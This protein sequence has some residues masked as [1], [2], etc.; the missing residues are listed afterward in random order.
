MCALLFHNALVFWTDIY[1]LNSISGIDFVAQHV[2]WND[3]RPSVATLNFR[4]ASKS[5]TLNHAVAKLAAFGITTVVSAGNEGVDASEYSPAS[6]PTAITVGATT[7]ADAKA[8]FSN[9]GDSVDIYAPGTQELMSRSPKLSH[10]SAQGTVL[11]LPGQTAQPKALKELPWLPA[12]SPAMLPI[13]LPS[14]LQ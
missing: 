10:L 11:S 3:S 9:W 4:T 8:T 6:E 1:I 7:I 12:L 14:T 5:D 2:Y 13:S